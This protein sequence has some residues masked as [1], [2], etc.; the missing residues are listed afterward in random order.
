MTIEPDGP[1]QPDGG[2]QGAD[3]RAG[4][5]HE[6]LVYELDEWNDEDKAKLST[7]LTIEGIVH[8]W[9]GDE[10]L[11][12]EADE[13][14]VDALLDQ[15]EFPD[16]LDAVDDD[17]EDDEERYETMADLFVAVDRLANANPV[18]VELAAE[19]ITAAQA[20]LALPQPFGIDDA[21]WDQVRRRSAAVAQA[22]QEET[23]DNVVVGDAAVLRDLLRTLV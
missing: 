14:R 4:D 20:V 8:Q 22:L 17:G 23:D 1:D 12:P 9:D 13:A 5:D 3:D 18:H 21:T 16:A 2:E 6:P 10:L 15:V 7:L 11:V 19:V